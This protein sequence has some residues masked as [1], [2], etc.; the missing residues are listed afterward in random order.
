MSKKISAHY[1][2]ELKRIIIDA[3]DVEQG[4]YIDLSNL[5]SLDSYIKNEINEKYKTIILDEYKNSDSF[6]SILNEKDSLSKIINELKQKEELQKTQYESK[7][8]QAILKFKDS[9]EYKDLC[10]AKSQ[11]ELIDINKKLEIEAAI[12]QNTKEIESKYKSEIEISNNEINDLKNQ[13][14]Q[15]NLEKDSLVKNKKIEID[16]ALLSFKNSEEYLDLL[17]VKKN[18]EEKLNSL[19]IQYDKEYDSLQTKI[20]DLQREYDS[21]T[22]KSIGEELEKYCYREY[23]DKFDQIWDTLFKKT[24]VAKDGTKPDFQLTIYDENITGKCDDEKWLKQHLIGNAIFEMKTEMNSSENKKKNDDHLKK[25][26]SDRIKFE[27][28]TAILVTE[29]ERDDVFQIRRS[30]IYPNIYLIR[31]SMFS[32][33][34]G[35]YRTMIIKNKKM[36]RDDIEFR[37]KEEI[38][39][40]FDEFVKQYFLDF[41]LL[42]NIA[43]N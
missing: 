17:N 35:L 13:L 14:K 36:H 11:L 30:K 7:I 21:K 31:P 12:S 20:Q 24:T 26:E 18:H 1:N 15:I 16:N 2:N 29:L 8:E 5:S 19:K 39:K 6:K 40:E 38:L 27:A 9:K 23:N 3:D 10:E 28:D 41:W 25:L 34:V 43:N 42:M 4:N 22:I 37:T 33:I 32:A